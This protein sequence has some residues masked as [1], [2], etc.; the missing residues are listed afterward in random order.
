[1]RRVISAHLVADDSHAFSYLP[2]E[3]IALIPAYS[4]SGRLQVNAIQVAGDGS[5]TE[6][7]TTNLPRGGWNVRTLPLDDRRFAV[8]SKG[9]IVEIVESAD[10]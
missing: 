8:V 2:A 9:R 10:L 7:A 3:R 5:L 6:L 4:G 1:V